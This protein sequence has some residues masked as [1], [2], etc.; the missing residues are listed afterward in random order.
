MS[1]RETQGI[2]LGNC[3]A[4]SRDVK[5]E[6]RCVEVEYNDKPGESDVRNAMVS[7]GNVV[8]LP[9]SGYDKPL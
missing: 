4:L 6:F 8:L 9:W 3:R 1:H 7:G 5:V 2:G